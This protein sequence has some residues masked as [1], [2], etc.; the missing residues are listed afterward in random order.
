[1]EKILVA[2]IFSYSQQCFI[3]MSEIV[4]ELHWFR[5][6]QLLSIW[7]RKN[8]VVLLTLSKQALVFM[9]LQYM[10]WKHC[11]KRRN[12]SWRAISPFPTVFS[13]HLE[14]FLP[15]SSNLKLLSA[16]TFSLE[17][18]KI[19]RLGKSSELKC[20]WLHFIITLCQKLSRLRVLYLILQPLTTLPQPLLTLKRRPLENMVGKGENA[21]N[22]LF[23][24]FSHYA[25]YTLSRLNFNLSKRIFSIP[26]SLVQIGRC[27]PYG[28][29]PTDRF[30]QFSFYDII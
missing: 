17:E 25:V 16:N 19:C 23:V 7:T 9:C 13:T 2:S 21:G 14:N 18:S 29:E 30:F 12:C 22:Q 24:L 3:P 10:A 15:F 6:M 5:C 20:S 4:N 26:I 1:M 27:R 28:S 11:G 8:F